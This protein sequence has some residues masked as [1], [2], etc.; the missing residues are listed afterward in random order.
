MKKCPFCSEE[1]QDSAKKCRHCWEWIENKLNDVTQNISNENG[2]YLPAPLILRFLTLVFDYI[3]IYCLAFLIGI[4]SW[5]LGIQDIIMWTND[6]ILWLWIIFS[7]YMIFESNSGRT[8]WKYIMGTKAVS[9]DGSDLTLKQSFLR[10]ICRFIPFE[11]LSFWS[12]RGWHDAIP[13]TIVIK[14]R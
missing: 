12:W 3:S 1:I 2:I 14:V 6:T 4:I 13:N 9:I 8:V 5:I 11:P 10:T 7:Y